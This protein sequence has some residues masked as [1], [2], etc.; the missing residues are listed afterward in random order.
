MAK[1]KIP[2]AFQKITGGKS[3]VE[4]QGGTLREAIA[5]LDSGYPGIQGKII[6]DADQIL[7]YVSIFVDGENARHLQGLDTRIVPSTQVSILVAV[8]GG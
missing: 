2:P 4:V 1:V 5:E 6:G 7:R 8:A 3:I